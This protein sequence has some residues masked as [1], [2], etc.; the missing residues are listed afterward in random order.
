MNK[1]ECY[2]GEIRNNNNGTR[3]E[4]IEVRKRSDIDVQFLDDH[5]YIKE[6]VQYRNF[7]LGQVKNPYDITVYT[8]GYLGVGEHKVS[9]HQVITDIYK[10]WSSMLRR[11]YSENSS[12]M[13]KSYFNKVEVCEEWHNFQNFGDW[14]E[15]NKY[16]C[17]GRLHIDKDIICPGNKFYSPDTCILVPQKINALF[18]NIPNKTGL[19]NGVRQALN[20]KYEAIFN[21]NSYGKYDTIEEAYVVHAK[22][23]KEHIVKTVNELEYKLPERL[24]DAIENFEFKIENDVNYVG[25]T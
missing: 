24:I 16:E 15:T 9:I 2:V 1:E 19:P 12:Y 25:N 8:A 5:K 14:Y 21:S 18:I 17:E 6:H 13:N 11:C 4:I 20:G 7:S 10:A 3:M 22:A 23:K